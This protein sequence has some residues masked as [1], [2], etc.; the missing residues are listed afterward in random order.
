MLQRRPT[1][2]QS[3]VAAKGASEVLETRNWGSGERALEPGSVDL[4]S[5]H[6]ET[7]EGEQACEWRQRCSVASRSSGVCAH[8]LFTAFEQELRRSGVSRWYV[9]S[10]LQVESGCCSFANMCCVASGLH[11]LRSCV[12]LLQTGGRVASAWLLARCGCGACASGGQRTDAMLQVYYVCCALVLR[13]L[14]FR[15]Q[16]FTFSSLRIG[17]C[18]QRTGILVRAWCFLRGL[19]FTLSSLRMAVCGRR[20]CDT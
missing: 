5:A 10:V 1:E 11:V 16:V 9:A 15:K 2:R 18:G 14:L 17:A 4:G 6:M 20:T 19:V 8:M 7:V 13:L 12:A 3:D